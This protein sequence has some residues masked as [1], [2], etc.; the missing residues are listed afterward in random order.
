VGQQDVVNVFHHAGDE[1]YEAKSELK[2]AKRHR[3]TEI[4]EFD[5][6]RYIEE[7]VDTQKL[8]LELLI[9]S[10]VTYEEFV[11]MYFKKS[12]VNEKRVRDNY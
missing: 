6:D 4:N 2:N 1:L 7:L 3:V 12:Y 11:D 9:M 5:R 8:L 10:N